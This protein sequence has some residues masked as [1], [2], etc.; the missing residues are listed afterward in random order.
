MGLAVGDAGTLSDGVGELG[1]PGSSLVGGGVLA[2]PPP[3]EESGSRDFE[4]VGRPGAGADAEDC[5]AEADALIE[6]PGD[7]PTPDADADAPGTADGDTE[8][9]PV[10][11]PPCPPG[12]GVEASRG[13]GSSVGTPGCRTGAIGGLFGSGFGVTPDTQA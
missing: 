1:V 5:G 10:P 2:V 7:G 3:V 6:V 4:P 8:A 12:P 9:P 13:E 11:Y